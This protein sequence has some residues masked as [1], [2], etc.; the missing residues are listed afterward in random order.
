MNACHAQGLACFLD[1]VYNHVGPEGSYL[2]EFGPYFTGHYRTP[3]GDAVNF[4]G[5][6]SEAVRAFVT[7]NVRMWI[8]DYHVDGLRLNAVHA[9]YDLG[10]RH[11]LQDSK[12]TADDAAVGA[13]IQR[14]SWQKAT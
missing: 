12:E 4:D 7:E 14:T 2:S 6:G 10:G 9:I 11:I 13:A 5:A 1:V 3:W 8:R